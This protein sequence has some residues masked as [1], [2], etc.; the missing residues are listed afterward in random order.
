MIRK[1]SFDTST[2]LLPCMISKARSTIGIMINLSE[3][4]RGCEDND[5]KILNTYV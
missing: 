1:A 5:A 2:S 3:M 4:G